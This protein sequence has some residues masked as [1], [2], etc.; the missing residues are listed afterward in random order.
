[1]TDPNVVPDEVV[2]RLKAERKFIPD[3]PFMEVLKWLPVPT[4]DFVPVRMNPHTD[5]MEFLLAWRTEEPFQNTWFVP[6]GR[7]NW[8]EDVE[9]MC[10]HHMK[11]EL[12]LEG[13]SPE[14]LFHHSVINP[15]S[16]SRP[17]WHSIW[18]FH[19]IEVPF[20][21]VI[22]SLAENKEVRWF[23]EIKIDFPEPVKTAL[24]KMGFQMED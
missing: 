7:M 2:A 24:L 14:F 18:M 9:T 16:P 10:L 6:G 20:D 22:K 1:M 15:A 11:R 12:G 13:L 17:I 23:T 4:T 21:L 3:A 5:K 19:M 8:G